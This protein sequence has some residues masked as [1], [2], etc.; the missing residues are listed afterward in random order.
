MF[1]F[2]KHP[3][4]NTG[5]ALFRSTK[6]ALLLDVRTEEEYAQGHIEQSVNLPLARIEEAPNIILDHELPIFV[7]CRSGARSETAVKQL[8]SMGYVNVTNIGG[9]I[10]YRDAD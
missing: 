1:T 4:I 8:K 9:I 2:R 5:I 6:P 7:Y 3:D 10:H